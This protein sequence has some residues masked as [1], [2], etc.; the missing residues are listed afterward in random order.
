MEIRAAD[1]GG[2]DL[3]DDVGGILDRRIGDGIDADVF[4]AVPDDCFHTGLLLRRMPVSSV[5]DA[6]GMPALRRV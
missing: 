1:G 2:G 3:D 4:L 5:R 6:R